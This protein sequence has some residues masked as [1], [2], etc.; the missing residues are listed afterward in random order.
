VIYLTLEENTQDLIWLGKEHRRPV[1]ASISLFR[2]EAVD[3][4]RERFKSGGVLPVAPPTAG[5]TSLLMILV[6]GLV[7][8]LLTCDYARK[9]TALGFLSPTLGVARVLPPRAG[10]VVA[11]HVVEGQEVAVGAPLITVQ[12]G[13]TNDRGGDVDESVLQALARQRG[14]LLDQIAEE[15]SRADAESRRLRDRIDGLGAEIAELERELN[16]Q[17]ARS[18]L[19]EEE[20]T[21]VRGLVSRG[22]V[23]VLESSGG[24]III[25]P[26]ARARRRW[27]SRSPQNEGKRLSNGMSSANSRAT[28]PRRYRHCR[29]PS[30]N[31][32]GDW[33]KR[34]AAG[35]T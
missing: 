1:M 12:V 31:W 5:L 16:A 14:A 7:A 4:Q 3:F 35:P 33:R 2:P 23:S 25:W 10:L 20:V 17:Q 11:V 30:L 6:A 18:R 13:A 9:E 34:K 29:R 8:F 21:A 26:N 32:T 19:A 22:Y 15:R 28:S 24:R 27:P